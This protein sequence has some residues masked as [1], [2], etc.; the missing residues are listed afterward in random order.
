MNY[1]GIQ[2]TYIWPTCETCLK[3]VLGASGSQAY[4]NTKVVGPGARDRSLQERVYPHVYHSNT[5]LKATY[6]LQ[7]IIWNIKLDL[8]NIEKRK[9]CPNKPH[10]AS[11]DNEP[12]ESP[13]T[14]NTPRRLR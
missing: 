2:A 1:E 12:H 10:N 4:F 11:L 13:K 3:Q 8:S 14:P 7:A 9:Y 5:R 6:E